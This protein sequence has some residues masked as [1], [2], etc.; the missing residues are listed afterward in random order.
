MVG[1]LAIDVRRRARDERHRQL[2]AVGKQ[3]IDAGDPLGRV[4]RLIGQ[5]AEVLAQERVAARR[6]DAG[7]DLVARQ[8]LPLD[9]DRPKAGV[10]RALRCGGAGEAGAD[11]EDVGVDFAQRRHSVMKRVSRPE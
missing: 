9:D 8:L 6:Q 10:H 2:Q 1:V 3:K 4:E 7:A 11:D 5:L